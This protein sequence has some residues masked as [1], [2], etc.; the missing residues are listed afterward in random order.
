L[1]K[2]YGLQDYKDIAAGKNLEFTGDIVPLAIQPTTWKCLRCGTVHRKSLRAILNTEKGCI[3]GSTKTWSDAKYN[4]LAKRW[5][6]TWTPEETKPRNTKIP[7]TWTL[8]DGKTKLVCS[9]FDLAY[10]GKMP[11]RVKKALGLPYRKKG[12]AVNV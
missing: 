5:G 1:P 6:I 2:R 12:G 8:K 3:C 11:N 4:A 10:D 7:T 9:Y